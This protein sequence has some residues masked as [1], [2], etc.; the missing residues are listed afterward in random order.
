MA[1]KL[2]ESS[3]IDL[4]VQFLPFDTARWN[5]DVPAALH[6]DCYPTTPCGDPGLQHLSLSAS[7]A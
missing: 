7:D 6:Y 2:A 4:E 5:L 1:A 3:M